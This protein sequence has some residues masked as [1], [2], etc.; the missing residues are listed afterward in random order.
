MSPEDERANQTENDDNS[1][2]IDKLSH[3]ALVT[4]NFSTIIM[5]NRSLSDL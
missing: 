2:A 3:C 1:I 4:T 5:Y